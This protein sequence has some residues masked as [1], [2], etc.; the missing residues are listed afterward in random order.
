MAVLVLVQ[1]KHRLLEELDTA[2]AVQAKVVVLVGV[3]QPFFLAQL[4]S[5][6]QEEAEADPHLVGTE[7]QAAVL[8]VKMEQ[9]E[10]LMA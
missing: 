6:L 2:Q 3:D 8:T 1:D 10:V 4:R 7:V 9:V 5:L